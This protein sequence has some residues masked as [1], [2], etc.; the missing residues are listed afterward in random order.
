MGQLQLGH[1]AQQ[2][3][4]LELEHWAPVVARGV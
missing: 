3:G 2:A 4:A 1:Y